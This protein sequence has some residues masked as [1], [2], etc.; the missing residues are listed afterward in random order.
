MM[1]LNQFCY[2]VAVKTKLIP[3]RSEI[4]LNVRSQLQW[5]SENSTWFALIS[6]CPL[7]PRCFT[8]SGVA[9]EILTK[10]RGAYAKLLSTSMMTTKAQISDFMWRPFQCSPE[11]SFFRL[12]ANCVIGQSL[13]S[14]LLFQDNLYPD[15]LRDVFSPRSRHLNPGTSSDTPELPREF[16]R[17]R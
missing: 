6:D 14:W 10:V 15:Q 12:F 4:F 8:T 3:Q 1:I 13:R 9:A 5:Y 11:G 16:H 17:K 2:W 7:S